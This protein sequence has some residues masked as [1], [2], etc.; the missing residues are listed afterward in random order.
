MRLRH[1]AESGARVRRE[2]GRRGGRRRARRCSVSPTASRGLS[3]LPDPT[4]ACCA[5]SSSRCARCRS[6]PGRVPVCPDGPAASTWSWCWRPEG[7]DP[8]TA[9][10]R[11]RGAYAAAAS[12]SWRPRRSPWSASTPQGRYAT[13]LPTADRRPAGHRRGG[14]RPARPGPPGTADRPRAWSP[15]P[16]TRSRS[17][18]SPHR[19]LAV[20]PAKILAIGI[21]D[22]NPVLWG[23]TVLAARAAR[24]IAE[25]SAGPPAEPRSP[26]TPSTCCPILAATAP[27]D[28][29]ADPFADG[30]RGTAPALLVLLDDGTRGA[31]RR[32]RRATGSSGRPRSTAYGSRRISLGGRRRRRAL[33]RDALHGHLRGGLP[34]R[35]GLDG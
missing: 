24:R 2:V 4:R 18:C 32:A 34:A 29:F 17:S 11:R 15:T 35:L 30:A 6:W 22:S 26:R 19:D 23:G 16:S 21:A 10:A 1:L 9:G 12:W 7:D 33:R 14:A 3:S 31:R 5:R 27:A 28:V 25:S 8:G 13:L 20:N